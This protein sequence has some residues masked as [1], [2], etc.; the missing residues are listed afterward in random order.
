MG[1]EF[2]DRGFLNAIHMMCI[3]KDGLYIDTG[4]SA[5]VYCGSWGILTGRQNFMTANWYF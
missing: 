2:H 5:S 3:Q 4:D 1:G